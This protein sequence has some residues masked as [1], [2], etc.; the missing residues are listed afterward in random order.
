MN[1]GSIF[2]TH[3]LLDDTQAT[4]S[5]AHHSKPIDDTKEGEEINP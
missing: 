2:L 3:Y 5:H 4:M 1:S